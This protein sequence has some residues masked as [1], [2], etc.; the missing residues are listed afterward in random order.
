V[1]QSQGTNPA[2]GGRVRAFHVVMV[3]AGLVLIGQLA[4]LLFLPKATP[5]AEKVAAAVEVRPTRTHTA[6]AT[7]LPPTA[8]PIPPTA[9]V[10]P[11]PPTAT[12]VPPTNTPEPPTAT[13]EPPTATSVPKS[14]T[15]VPPRPTA[16][17]PKPT[18]APVAVLESIPVDNG[19][20]GK[21]GIYVNYQEAIYAQASNGQ[22]YRCEIGFLSSPSALQRAQEWWTWAARGGGNWKMILLMRSKV[23]WNHCGSG[24]N[25]CNQT[26]VNAGQSSFQVELYIKPHV[27]ESLL[28][29]YI[30]GG[31]AAVQGN[32]YYKQIQ[33]KVFKPICGA[34]GTPD[35]PI[36]GFKFTQ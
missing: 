30:R 25:I 34:C 7:P 27:W 3:L 24:D 26:S 11:V 23:T 21:E 2:K 18:A 32:G 9:T 8:T 10:T 35:V 12:S 31:Q 22:R 5:Q 20:F 15:P 36:I 19:T 33:E 16:V 13:P 4:A 6:T 28:N 17:P 1:T 29:D 14:A